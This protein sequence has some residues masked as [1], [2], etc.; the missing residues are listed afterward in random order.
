MEFLGD[1]VLELVST[2]F[3]YNKYPGKPEGDL[4]AYRSALVN[5][6]TLARVATKLLMNNYLLLSHGE[7]KYE[8]LTLGKSGG[9]DDARWFKMADI[10]TLNLYNDILPIVT[11]AI[12]MLLSSK[13]KK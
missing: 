10:V 6:V 2:H 7:A 13:L 8:N 11:K 12:N 3:L 4:T 9:L 5:A 1:A